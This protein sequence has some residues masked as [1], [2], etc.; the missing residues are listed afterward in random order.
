MLT[1]I[2]PDGAAVT[3][4]HAAAAALQQLCTEGSTVQ[5]ARNVLAAG[6]DYT[7]SSRSA[8]IIAVKLTDYVPTGLT[9]IKHQLAEALAGAGFERVL[10]DSIPSIACTWEGQQMHVVLCGAT[11]AGVLQLLDPTLSFSDRED[12]AC[13]TI[14]VSAAFLQQQQPALYRTAARVAY[15]WAQKQLNGKVARTDGRHYK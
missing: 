13:G 4:T 12:L 1:A 3:R 7:A 11:H 14:A 6:T 9:Q 10:C 2:S 15:L 8:A 5:V